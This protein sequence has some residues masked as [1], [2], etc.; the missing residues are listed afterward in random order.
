MKAGGCFCEKLCVSYYH[1]CSSRKPAWPWV[2]K[3]PG[4]KQP[5]LGG[6]PVSGEPTDTHGREVANIK[7]CFLPVEATPRPSSVLECKGITF[8]F[9]D[10]DFHVE[11]NVSV[12]RVSS[13]A[14]NLKTSSLFIS[15]TSRLLETVPNFS[16]A[17]QW[18]P[19]TVPSGGS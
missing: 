12:S 11:N 18:A 15:R 10:T 7:N 6:A 9:V 1:R 4:V 3:V 19:R 13:A 2:P 8:P 16:F 14:G 17:L 5:V